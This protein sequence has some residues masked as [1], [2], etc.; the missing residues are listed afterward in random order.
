M[1]D[2]TRLNNLDFLKGYF[3]LLALYQ[4]F[5]FFTNVWFTNYF[6]EFFL[7]DTTY[8]HFANMVDQVLPVTEANTFLHRWFTPW[9][10]QIY[11]ML[12]AFNLSI[13]KGEEFNKQY[14]SK[15]KIFGIL[16]LFFFMENFLIARSYGDVFVLYPLLTWMIVLSIIA[17]LYRYWGLKAVVL[18]FTVHLLKWVLPAD[19]WTD[20]F[21]KFM[22]LKF[23]PGFYIDARIDHFFGSGC[24]GFI[25]GHIFFHS[26]I[27]DLKKYFIPFTIGIGLAAYWRY[28]GPAFYIDRENVLATEHLA[29][30]SVSGT[31][32]IWGI[33]LY[34][35]S[36]FLYLEKVKNI[37]IKAPIINW[38]GI[39]S[40]TPFSIHRV[41]FIYMLM[42]TI[43]YIYAKF[44]I[45]L[46][47]SLP[48]I[49]FCVGITV[50][51]SW[52]IRKIKMHQIIFK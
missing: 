2:N 3:I 20:S 47:N 29:T 43:V 15:I 19:Q 42:P 49:W 31:L 23:H 21:V 7:I 24:I 17:T 52:F 33:Q 51:V 35:V 16:F 36:L 12:A 45:V 48:F 5:C 28:F 22:E 11:L 41:F 27:N 4:H 40:L 30:E 9:V 34:V 44:N 37:S 26:K 25:Y 14:F 13:R 6:Y 8:S 38:V 32:G 1:S 50:F 10:S 18:A 39:H 46:V